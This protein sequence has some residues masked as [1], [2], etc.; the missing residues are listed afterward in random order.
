MVGVH[1]ATAHVVAS[2]HVL[3]V[4]V[5]I[6][7]VAR[8]G[9]ERRRG[10][11]RRKLPH[12]HTALELCAASDSC[13]QAWGPRDVDDEIFDRRAEARAVDSDGC[14][15]C[16][17]DG[18][19]VHRGDARHNF[20]GVQAGGRQVHAL[21]GRVDE[22][23]PSVVARLVEVD[24]PEAGRGER[25]EEEAA[26]Q[27]GDVVLIQIPSAARLSVGQCAAGDEPAAAAAAAAAA[28]EADCQVGGRQPGGAKGDGLL[29]E[30]AQPQQ[31]AAFEDRRHDLADPR[32][33]AHVKLNPT[34]ADPGATNACM[35]SIVAHGLTAVDDDMESELGIVW[36]APTAGMLSHKIAGADHTVNPRADGRKVLHEARRRMRIWIIAD[37]DLRRME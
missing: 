37:E 21:S 8:G 1:V 12:C 31:L 18:R 17:R 23:A 24:S 25:I 26:A 35:V 16:R 14:P 27:L 9:V 2:F 22:S 34:V 3:A 7:H 30:G 36:L 4:H 32:S 13:R 29:G 15:T 20:G 11:R 6:V 5:A 33:T 19:G 28:V 10:R